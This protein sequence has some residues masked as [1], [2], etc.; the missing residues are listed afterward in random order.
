M[1]TILDKISDRGFQLKGQL[2]FYFSFREQGYVNVGQY[3][4]DSAFAVNQSDICNDLVGSGFN[5]SD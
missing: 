1:P 2:I 5:S 3:P 4:I